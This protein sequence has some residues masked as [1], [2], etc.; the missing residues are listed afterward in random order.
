MSHTTRAAVLGSLTCVLLAGS[1]QAQQ[2]S[3]EEQEVLDHV[4]ECFTSFAEASAQ[5][6]PQIWVQRCRPVDESLYWTASEAGPMSLKAQVKNWELSF[7]KSAMSSSTGFEPIRMR[8][9]D[10]FAFVYGYSTWYDESLEGPSKWTHDARL[11]IYRRQEGQWGLFSI[12]WMP[13]EVPY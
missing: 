10:D 6:D 4:A 13:M 5:N 2:W 8:L 11:E 12:I 3:E 9:V 7:P 1:V